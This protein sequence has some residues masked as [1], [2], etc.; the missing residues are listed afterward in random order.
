MM[1]PYGPPVQFTGIVNH[2]N[3]SD[4]THPGTNPAPIAFLIG[5]KSPIHQLAA[6]QKRQLGLFINT[7]DL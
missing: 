6:F 7:S 5:L 3:V 4:G 1:L 2:P